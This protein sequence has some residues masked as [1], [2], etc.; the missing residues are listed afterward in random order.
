[1]FRSGLPGWLVR[2]SSALLLLSAL[3]TGPDA[4]AQT[5][6][7]TAEALFEQG[8]DLLRAGKTT[9]AC[10]KLAE[11]Q[12]LDPATGTL[13]ALAMCHEADG[14]L[15]SAWAEFVSAEALSRNEGRAD[16]EEVAQGRVQALRPR[17]STLEIRVPSQVA[18]LAGVEIR[19]DG[20]VLGGGAWNVAVPVDGG[21]H[22]VAVTAPGKI[23]WQGTSVVK[24]QSDR[25]VLEVPALQP[26][27]AGPS[28]APESRSSVDLNSPPDTAA[29][30]RWGT[31]EWAGV[32][33]AGAGVVA[34]GIGG[35]FLSSALGKKSDSKSDC[36]GNACGDEGYSQRSDAVSRGN[37][38]TIL[39]VAGGVLVAA[40][41]TLFVV[42]R[43]KAKP[44]RADSGRREGSA[45]ERAALVLGA[46][47]AGL[48]AQFSTPF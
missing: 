3:L 9:E 33:T 47:P 42:G 48:G 24:A 18:I 10:P 38:A 8:R 16:R 28:R 20:I 5:D 27:P 34:L 29:R 46:S 19:R 7:A 17:L 12:R 2:S 31:L 45:P 23:T 44:R 4:L 14:K 41:A 43:V 36:S 6:A 13:L 21:E 11:S 22:V 39:G 32:G 30:G 40:G 15:A 1:M 26:A 35:F 25:A 37:T